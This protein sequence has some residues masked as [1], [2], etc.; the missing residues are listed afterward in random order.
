MRRALYEAITDL[1]DNGRTGAVK[2]VI[3]LTDGD[4]N[5]DGSYPRAWIPYRHLIL[6]GLEL[7]TLILCML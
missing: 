2:A 4:W 7:P 6:H 1:D 5:Y 3:L